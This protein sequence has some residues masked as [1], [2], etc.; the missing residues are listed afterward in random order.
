MTLLKGL[1]GP[2]SSMKG[3]CGPFSSRLLARQM[4]EQ[5]SLPQGPV[6]PKPV[7]VC[8]GQCTPPPSSCLQRTAHSSLPRAAYSTWSLH[9]VKNSI[10]LHGQNLNLQLVGQKLHPLRRAAA[11]N[12]ADLLRALPRT[13]PASMSAAGDLRATA[14][15]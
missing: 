6:R 4:A 12:R 14:P 10:L 1:C 7:E 3:L 2:F 5:A 11:G 9:I 13:A 15:I 8:T